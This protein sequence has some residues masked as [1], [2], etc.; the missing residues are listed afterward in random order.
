MLLNIAAVL[1][2]CSQVALVSGLSGPNGRGQK[3]QMR[4]RRREYEEPSQLR[5]RAEQIVAVNT[6][7]SQFLVD[8]T[9]LPDV[10]F[11]IGQAFA[12]QLP[13]SQEA[14]ESRKL[15]FFF[16]PSS[17]P[18][19]SDEITIWCRSFWELGVIFR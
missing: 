7:T 10:D 11:D 13:I 12:G 8:G 3:Q 19:A 4:E 14:N 16:S 15:Y 2:L 6:N 5:G 17:D 9:A 18:A 1:C